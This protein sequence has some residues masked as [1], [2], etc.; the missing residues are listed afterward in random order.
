MEERFELRQYIEALSP[1]IETALRDNL[2][3]DPANPENKFNEALEYAIPAEERVHAILTLLGAETVGGKAEDVLPAAVAV[4]F[5]HICSAIFDGLAASIDGSEKRSLAKEIGGARAFRAALNLLNTAYALVLANSHAYPERAIQAH[6]E[7]VK[8]VGEDGIIG[9]GQESS[10][11]TPAEI[12]Y[13]PEN[14]TD[15]KASA[16]LRLALRVG[17]VLGGADYLQLEA[18]SR[19]AALFGDAYQVKQDLLKMDGGSEASAE[20]LMV[21]LEKGQANYRLNVLI[22]EAKQI[23]T[24]HFPPNEPVKILLQLTDELAAKPA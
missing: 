8:C 3:A 6:N 19:F 4:E 21:E 16:S 13:D 11:K 2:P 15:L 5:V 24:A 7:L 14:T 23:L 20:T 18:L 10:R 17:G 9:S 22:D 12:D 1:V